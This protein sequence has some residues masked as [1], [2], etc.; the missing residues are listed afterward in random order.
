MRTTR[1]YAAEHLRRE[2]EPVSGAGFMRFPFV[3]Q[4]VSADH[5][6]SGEAALATV[7]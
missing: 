4:H 6:R 7:L 5:R 3:W 1:C 2:I